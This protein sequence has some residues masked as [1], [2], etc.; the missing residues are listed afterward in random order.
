D[1]AEE[2]TWRGDRWQWFRE[3][4][5]DDDENIMRA[6]GGCVVE[7]MVKEA[8]SAPG[9]FDEGVAV[10]EV[11]W[12]ERKLQELQ[13][14][15][16]LALGLVYLR[17]KRGLNHNFNL[18]EEGRL[19]VSS[20]SVRTGEESWYQKSIAG[21]E[22]KQEEGPEYGGKTVSWNLGSLSEKARWR[23]PRTDNRK[24]CCT[25][26]LRG[27]S[28]TNQV[29]RGI[30]T[31]NGTVFACTKPSL[32]VISMGKSRGYFRKISIEEPKLDGGV[33]KEEIQ[34]GE[35][36]TKSERTRDQPRKREGMTTARAS[37]EAK[38][39]GSNA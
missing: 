29:M 18:M 30:Q 1:G 21:L 15:S 3:E 27:L 17:R 32:H 22:Q 2:V 12:L 20:A 25:T 24:D 5:D 28:T 19:P 26:K 36:T 10:E 16:Y 6:G 39:R 31:D 4:L 8:Q 23:D 33:E 35:K 9:D 38:T 7:E 37:A 34:K 14:S 13:T 11:K